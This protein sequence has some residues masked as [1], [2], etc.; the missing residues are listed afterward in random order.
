MKRASAI[1]LVTMVVLG[2][3]A[4]GIS[5][6]KTTPTSE[7]ARFLTNVRVNKVLCKEWDIF[8]Q[9]A[10][11]D[12][13]GQSSYS[14]WAEVYQRKQE[15]A[16]TAHWI[17]SELRN[18]SPPQELESIWGKL[19]KAIEDY[20]WAIDPKNVFPDYLIMPPIYQNFS[21]AW[22][23]LTSIYNQEALNPPRPLFKPPPVKTPQ[24]P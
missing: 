19:M 3:L 15:L 4:S 18:I 23:D 12:S 20:E 13:L 8:D 21:L 17:A 5:C 16:P 7:N 9:L 6:T 1:L 10:T 22:F 24:S 11:L 14:T 2:L